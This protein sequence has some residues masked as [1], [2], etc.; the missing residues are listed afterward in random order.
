MAKGRSVK[1]EYVLRIN[2]QA[3]S[4]NAA[5]VSCRQIRGSG[6]SATATSNVAEV[7]VVV[8]S[9]R[10]QIAQPN[11]GDRTSF[12]TMQSIEVLLENTDFVWVFVPWII[13]QI[14]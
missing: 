7:A 8:I 11:T 3:A 2:W 12:S 10:R 14:S 9:P 1:E 5:A 4:V 6:G 13:V